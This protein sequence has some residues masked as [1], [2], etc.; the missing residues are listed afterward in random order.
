MVVETETVVKKARR[1]TTYNSTTFGTHHQNTG[2]FSAAMFEFAVLE[3]QGKTPSR[4]SLINGST[5]G[6]FRVRE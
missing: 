2:K 4:S 3:V 1:D 5:T 6:A